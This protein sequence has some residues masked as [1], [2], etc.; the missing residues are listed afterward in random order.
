MRHI[1]KNNEKEMISYIEHLLK[2]AIYCYG[3]NLNMIDRHLVCS[4]C[5]IHIGPRRRKQMELF[6]KKESK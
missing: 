2:G 5:R 1:D 6:N 4:G 3:S